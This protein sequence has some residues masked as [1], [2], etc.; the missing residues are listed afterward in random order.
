MTAKEIQHLYWRAGFGIL[1]KALKQ[2]QTENK[3]AILKELFQ[4]SKNITPLRLDISEVEYKTK[5]AFKKKDKKSSAEIQKMNRK[6]IRD[7]NLAWIDRLINPKEILRE[8]MTLFWANHFVVR[9]NRISFV[10]D[11]NNMLRKHALGN[12]GD[13]VKAMSKEAAML[14]YLNNKQNRKQSPNENFARE[15]IELFTLGKG[16]YT[17]Q[18]IKE[19]A[20]AFTGYFHN[21]KGEFVIRKAQ[22]DDS[23]KTFF[24]KTGN[25]DGDDIIDI[26]LQ[27]KQCA[28][29]ISK[30]IY[31]YFINENVN[32]EHVEEMTNV[33]FKNY[34]IEKLIKHVFS[35]N[36]FYSDENVGTKIKSP[37][38]LLVGIQNIVPIT[39]GKEKALQYYQKSLGQILLFPPNVAGWKGGKSWIDSNTIV[40]RMR[41]P[42]LFL[43]KI[44]IPV[45]RKSDFGDPL[46]RFI[47][48]SG[49]KLNFFK[50]NANWN[51]FESNFKMVET[52]NL[53]EYIIVPELNPETKN[54]LQK[55]SKSSKEDYCIQLM[56]IP[57]YQMC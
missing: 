37:I 32:K 49:E 24:G 10:Q 22:H 21:L 40:M 45:K 13:F 35:S 16:N 27:E 15:L 33:F 5:Q 26:I 7:Y 9:D 1:P 11:Y 30:K 57:E 25:F 56:S 34:D 46:S 48:R 14:K 28:R 38:D 23:P 20:R 4:N 18:D 19:S 31:R 2:K 29:F 39:F 54:Y 42:S 3:K 50:T 12:F 53:S 51:T 43:N 36:W 52:K 55:L 41:F 8:R 47:V 44:H 17:E 6:L